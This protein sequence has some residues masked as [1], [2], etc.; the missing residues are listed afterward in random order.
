MLYRPNELCRLKQ[1]IVISSIEP[2]VAAAE[3]D[4]I[5]LS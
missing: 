4:D 1:C 3:L 5:E 2:G